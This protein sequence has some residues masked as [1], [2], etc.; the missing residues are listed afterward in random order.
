MFSALLQQYPIRLYNPAL[1]FLTRMILTPPKTN[2][3]AVGSDSGSAASTRGAWAPTLAAM[4]RQQRQQQRWRRLRG[5]G[6]LSHGGGGSQ[7]RQQ[8][9]RG[10]GLAVG[11]C[12][13]DGRRGRGR[14][15]EAEALG[16]GAL[17]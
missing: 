2:L 9:R 10:E 6:W 4:S 14:R 13:L 12:Q 3:R 16:M 8:Q 5:P 17:S 7:Q 1:P 15:E 11:A